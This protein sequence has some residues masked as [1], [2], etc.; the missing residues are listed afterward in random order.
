MY[1]HANLLLVF[2]EYISIVDFIAS[3]IVKTDINKEE[4]ISTNINLSYESLKILTV[5]FLALL[6]SFSALSL[7]LD[8]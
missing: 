4:R 6:K 1:F 3:A 2:G 5:V 7:A 8:S